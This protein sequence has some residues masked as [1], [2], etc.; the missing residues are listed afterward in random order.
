MAPALEHFTIGKQDFRNTNGCLRGWS[1]VLRAADALHRLAIDDFCKQLAR[2]HPDP[3]AGWLQGLL[4]RAPHPVPS[5]GPWQL[6]DRELPAASQHAYTV[7][8]SCWST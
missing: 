6:L 8:L 7:I 3:L 2:R 5:A 4:G 1:T